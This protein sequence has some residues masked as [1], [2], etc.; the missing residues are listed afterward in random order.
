[1]PSSVRLEGMGTGERGGEGKSSGGDFPPSGFIP[2]P[3]EIFLEYQQIPIH[4]SQSLHPSRTCWQGRSKEMFHTARSKFK[5]TCWCAPPRLHRGSTEAPPRLH[6]GAI[7]WQTEEAQEEQDTGGG[8]IDRRRDNVATPGLHGGGGR[9]GREGVGIK[10]QQRKITMTI[11]TWIISWLGLRDL[12]VSN[13]NQEEQRWK[14]RWRMRRRRRWRI[15][16][17]RDISCRHSVSISFL[18]R[19]DPI[20]KWWHDSKQR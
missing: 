6:R 4:I 12:L 13:L 3:S 10:Q 20:G 9:W 8:I 17:T 11:F 5:P 2:V 19:P 15:P 1:M 7:R 14:C 16:A 18:S